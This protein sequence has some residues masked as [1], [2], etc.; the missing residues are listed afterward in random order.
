[1][2]SLSPRLTELFTDC[3]DGLFSPPSALR[4]TVSPQFETPFLLLSDDRPFITSKP[5]FVEKI[6][7]TA[8][9]IE[10]RQKWKAERNEAKAKGLPPPKK[11]VLA[12]ELGGKVPVERPA[13]KKDAKGP[14]KGK[15]KGPRVKKSEKKKSETKAAEKELLPEV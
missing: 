9:E 14:A 8:E 4:F 11:P 1:L 10:I 5:R 13:G 3:S 6:K 15:G 12:Y 7:P 2:R